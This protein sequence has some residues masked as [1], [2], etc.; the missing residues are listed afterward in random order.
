MED[1]IIVLNQLKREDLFDTF[2]WKKQVGK[3]F[4]LQIS[5]GLVAEAS[6]FAHYKE[7][8]NLQDFTIEL[9]SMSKCPINCTFC[10]ATSLDSTPKYLSAE[11][12]FSQANFVL[13]DYLKKCNNKDEVLKKLFISF[14]GIGETSLIADTILK[15]IE[16]IKNKYPTSHFNIATMGAKP[17]EF[18]KF[19]SIPDLI[20]LQLAI[21]HPLDSEA[22]KIFVG[23]KNY[24]IDTIL[25]NLNKFMKKNTLARIRI[26]YVLLDKFNDDTETLELLI[27]KLKNN[28][29]DLSRIA[30]KLSYLNN[31][32]TSIENKLERPANEKYDALK[33]FLEKKEINCYLFGT[34]ENIFIS[35]G[36]LIS[37][38]VD[39]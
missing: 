17:N 37:N 38:C 15:S 35:C 33:K 21:Y 20:T 14:Y 4:V 12:I 31:T 23:H 16:L 27:K 9:S 11:Q 25:L 32:V 2:Y 24:S 7:D 36:Q 26:N 34:K 28:Q 19:A 22:K 29:L 18:E 6:W 39:K 10:G 30:I 3:R 1:K 8:G 5:K 13:Q